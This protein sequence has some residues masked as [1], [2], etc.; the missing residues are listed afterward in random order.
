MSKETG[1]NPKESQWPKLEQHRQQNKDYGIVLKLA[2][3]T[4]IHE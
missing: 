4:N 2:E 3:L 1:A